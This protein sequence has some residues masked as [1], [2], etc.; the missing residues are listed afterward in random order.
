MF[1]LPLEW[2]GKII[3]VALVGVGGSGSYMA[4]ELIRLDTALRA[5]SP[6]SGLNVKVFDSGVV[7]EANIARQAFFPT[8]H[9]M[10][11]ADATVWTANNLYGKDWVAAPIDFTHVDDSIDLIITAVDRPS[12]RY[13]LSKQESR[14]HRNKLWLDMGNSESQGQVVI[15]QFGKHKVLPHICDLYD[16]SVLSD[17]DA[18]IKSCSANESLTRQE[19]GVNQFAARIS[20]QLLWN[21]FRHGS[22]QSQG[23][24]FDTKTLH[25]DPIMIDPSVWAIYGYTPSEEA[26]D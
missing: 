2:H 13:N 18:L 11:K 16:Y 14:F 24:Y 17:K 26:T 5:I 25:V 9:G 4:Q 3:R 20:A 19:L 8:Q 23:A 1:N 22:I 15:G 6:D 10:N 12:V 21:L 7:T